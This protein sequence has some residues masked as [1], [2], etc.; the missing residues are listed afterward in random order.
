MVR[1]AADGDDGRLLID[2]SKLVYANQ[3]GLG[4]LERGILALLPP[5]V[6]CPTL[7][8][9]IEVAARR[10]RGVAGRAVD[11]GGSTLPLEDSAADHA[12]RAEAVE[13]ACQAADC[14]FHLVRSI[15]ICPLRFNAILDAHGS[16]GAVLAEALRLLLQTCQATLPGADPLYFFID[17]HGGRNTYAAQIQHASGRHGAGANRRNASSVYDVIG[18]NRAVRLTFQPRAC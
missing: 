13:Q 4:A 16:K 1:R 15:V 9:F 14:G 18:L 8:H 10:C 11:H 2:D 3:C 7:H 6:G 12:G 5:S 17:K